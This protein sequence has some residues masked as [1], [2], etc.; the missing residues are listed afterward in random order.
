MQSMLFAH[1]DNYFALVTV[2]RRGQ[3]LFARLERSIRVAFG[4]ISHRRGEALT[5]VGRNTASI[6][7]AGFGARLDR[8]LRQRARAIR[9]CGA[10][11]IRCLPPAELSRFPV[12][13]NPRRAAG[14]RPEG[15]H[16]LPRVCV[17]IWQMSSMACCQ[18]R[19]WDLVALPES[20]WSLGV[21]Q[22]G[23]SRC[24][25]GENGQRLGSCADSVVHLDPDRLRR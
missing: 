19:M 12:P 21:G 8:Y 5:F 20:V 9:C 7:E 11:T 17:S 14:R 23:P 18:A 10:Q 15:R 22:R 4:S 6:L 13:L 3:G 25:K 1:A 2:L 16:L 24:T